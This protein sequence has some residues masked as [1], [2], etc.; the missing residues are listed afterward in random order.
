MASII[1]VA[2]TNVLEL[3]GLKSAIEDAFINDATVT[4]TLKDSEGNAVTGQ[5]WPTTMAY[6]AAS[7][8]VYR[9][10]MKDGLSIVAADD[11]S[12]EGVGEY[13]AFIEANAGTDRIGHW[14]FPV[15]AATRVS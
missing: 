5:T 14:E 7:D 4:V 1:Y 9:A 3:S 10:I 2:N 11:D 13:T 12:A 6:V 15:T 8:G